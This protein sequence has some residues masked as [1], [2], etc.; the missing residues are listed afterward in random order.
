SGGLKP[1]RAVLARTMSGPDGRFGFDRVGI[2]PRQGEAIDNLLRG[3]GGAE[4]LAWADGRAMTW[5]DVK[6]L[7]PAE[8]VRLALAPEAVVAGVVRDTDGRGVPDVR[9]T[10]FGVTRATAEYDAAFRQP[11]ELNLTLSDLS[12]GAT[13]DAE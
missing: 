5:V 8:P 7:A 12:P 2:P 9:V 1:N 13:T 10:V 3:L 6:R 4:L 11:G